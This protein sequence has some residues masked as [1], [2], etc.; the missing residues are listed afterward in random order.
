MLNNG[1]TCFL[2]TRILAPRSRY[3]EIVELF[4]AIAGSLPVGDPLDP[5]TVIGPMASS[6]QRDRVESYIAKGKSDG[7]R[8]TVGGGRP[9]ALGKGWYVEPT[10]FAD[11]DNS[12][13]IAQ[14]EIFGPV[15]SILGYNDEDHAVAIANNSKYGLS[16]AVW[17]GSDAE[18]VRVAR[19]VRTGQ[20]QIN[21]GVFNGFA[22]FGGFKKSGIGRE[23]GVYGMLEFSEVKSMQLPAGSPLLA[24]A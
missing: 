9:S 20:V 15:L 11:V 5:A 17:A 7:A 14:E 6:R 8:L 16:G 22:P 4:T 10:V 19:R 18:A 21:S 2:G 3:D 12:S 24:E 23:G 1:Q 13:T